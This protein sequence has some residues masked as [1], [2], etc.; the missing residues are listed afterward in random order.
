MAT[1][2]DQSTELMLVL[3]EAERLQL[4]TW[5]QQIQKGKLVEEH[6]TRSLEYRELVLREERT[7]TSLIGK[8]SKI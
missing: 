3:T 7:L 2:N 1:I 4:L 6:R 8:L 5:L